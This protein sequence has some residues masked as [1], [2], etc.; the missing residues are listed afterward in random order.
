MISDKYKIN[1]GMKDIAPALE[2]IE[3]TAAYC[4]FDRESTLQLRLM[5]EE[6]LGMMQGIMLDYDG[7][8]WLDTDGTTMNLHTE[9]KSEISQS[10]REKLVS[11]ASSGQNTKPKGF[12]NKLRCLVESAFYSDLNTPPI[13]YANECSFFSGDAGKY[14]YVWNYSPSL[15][16]STSQQ[17]KDYDELEMSVLAKLSD[18]IVVSAYPPRIS[19]TVSKSFHK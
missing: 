9:V 2:I 7:E 4:G 1:S 6:L 11:I 14:G 10:E 12:M 3:K 16:V 19:L 15:E 8:F 13:Y 17:N 5:G 18:N